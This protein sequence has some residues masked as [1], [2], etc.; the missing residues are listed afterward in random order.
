M[1]CIVDEPVPWLQ[2]SG[3]RAAVMATAVITMGRTRNGGAAL[4]RGQ[5]FGLSQRRAFV[6]AHLPNRWIDE[7]EQEHADL[8]GY[9]ARAI[10][11]T[12][13][14]SDRFEAV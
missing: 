1:R 3:N 7:G 6:C 8:R 9:A 10:K 14:A 2:N 5:D 13:T 4:R 12:A 11:P